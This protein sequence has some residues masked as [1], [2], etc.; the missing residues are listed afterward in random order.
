MFALAAVLPDLPILLNA[1][2]GS[3]RRDPV[4][5]TASAVW[6]SRPLFVAYR[7]THSVWPWLVLSFWSFE[8]LLGFL[9]HWIM[10]L[11]HYGRLEP[12][13]LYPIRHRT[14]TAAVVPLSGGHDSARCLAVARASF[15]AHAIRAVFVDYGQEQVEKERAAAVY[16]CHALNVRLEQRSIPSIRKDPDGCYQDRNFRI[17]EEALAGFPVDTPLTVF[18]GTRVPFAILD[19]YGDCAPRTIR[20]WL[21]RRSAAYRGAFPCLCL[22]DWWIRSSLRSN[23]LDISNLH[24]S[25]TA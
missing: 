7:L 13:L 4:W 3:L 12:S 6:M 10:D 18:V 23:H 20:R 11:A 14:S 17:L 5:Q 25:K 21:K 15:P 2:K 16:L 24:S 9:L 22:P 8:W 1:V 19:K